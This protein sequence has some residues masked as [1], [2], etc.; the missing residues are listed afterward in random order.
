MGLKRDSDS[1]GSVCLVYSLKRGESGQWSPGSSEVES[2]TTVRPSRLEDHRMSTSECRK[3]GFNADQLKI[4]KD[5]INKA[6]QEAQATNPSSY[7]VD[8]RM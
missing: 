1:E 3:G 5:T 7:T 8:F 2:V 6:H 4:W